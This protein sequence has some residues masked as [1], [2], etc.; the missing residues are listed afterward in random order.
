MTKVREKHCINVTAEVEAAAPSAVTRA[1]EDSN[2]FR[3][4][5][6]HQELHMGWI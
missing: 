2:V 3:G 1:A 6:Y 5:K 4:L